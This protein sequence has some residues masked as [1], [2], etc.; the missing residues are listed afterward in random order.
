M[1][2]TGMS[3]ISNSSSTNKK[4]KLSTTERANSFFQ[5]SAEMDAHDRAHDG[6]NEVQLEDVVVPETAPVGWRYF[7]SQP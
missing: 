7:L 4:G 2:L 5:L 6:D 3:Q 1:K